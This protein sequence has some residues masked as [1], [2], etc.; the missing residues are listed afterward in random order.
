[1]AVANPSG[2]S[3]TPAYGNIQEELNKRAQLALNKPQKLDIATSAVKRIDQELTLQREFEKKM[4]AEGRVLVT[5]QGINEL[6]QGLS[7]RTGETIDPAVFSK[8][9]GLYVKPQEAESFAF[10]E[11]FAK[12]FKDKQGQMAARLAPEEAAKQRMQ[13]QFT[14]QKPGRGQF[15]GTTTDGQNAIIFNPTTN[16]FDVQPLPTGGGPMNPK[17]TG[18]KLTSDQQTQVSIID[19]QIG[20][21]GEMKKLLDKIP[22]GARGASASAAAKLTGGKTSPE[23]KNYSDLVNANAVAIYRAYTGDTRLSDADAQERAYKLLPSPYE[24]KETREK[25]LKILKQAMNSRKESIMGLAKPTFG[26]GSGV[27]SSGGRILRIRKKSD[28]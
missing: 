16:T 17:V 25:K 14:E 22:T 28:K 6:V 18:T 12:T 9:K 8:F 7:K 26:P 13:A 15:V 24:S 27:T 11:V 21:I 4:R 5:D 10:Q 3:L 1:M 23:A 19:S 2:R 20:N